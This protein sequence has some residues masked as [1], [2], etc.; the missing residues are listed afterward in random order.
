MRI[1]PN[2]RLIEAMA[3]QPLSWR[4]ALTEWID[5]SLD[6]GATAVTVTVSRAKGKSLVRIDDNGCG[7]ESLE[8]FFKFGD[9]AKHKTS[10]S[11]RYGIG[12]KDAA[13]YLGGVQSVFHVESVRAGV[14]RVQF[15]DWNR[16]IQRGEW[17]IDDHTETPVRE[18]HPSG[19]TIVVAPVCRQVPSGQGWTRLLDELAYIYSPALLRGVQISVRP[20]YDRDSKREPVALLKGWQPTKEIEPD[21]IQTEIEVG[22]K[23]AKVYAAIVRDGIVNER[24]GVTYT[25]GFRVIVPSTH[26]GCG[27]A[28]ISRI[29][30]WVHIDDSWARN[31][32]KDGIRDFEALA[33]AVEHA[34]APILRRAEQ[35][36]SELRSAAFTSAVQ[37]AVNA[38]LVNDAK[39]VRNKRRNP[40]GAVRPTGTGSRHRNAAQKQPG[41]TMPSRPVGAL[42]IV[43]AHLGADGGA[44]RL[45]GGVVTLNLDNAGI[46]AARDSE[47]VLA[48]KFAID[49]ILAAEYAIRGAS[50]LRLNVRNVGDDEDH[51][52]SFSAV[53]GD[54]LAA[55][56]AIDGRPVLAEVSDQAAE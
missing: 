10:K 19:T 24:P 36:G 4:V 25:H 55:A 6:A 30:A 8:P 32:N 16:I 39:A 28:P 18:G 21:H 14:R 37:N 52:R 51:A 44:G 29:V 41:E 50:Q 53:Y 13:L 35:A 9:H 27:N 7:R 2:A 15:A 48:A 46:R 22:G 33:R 23:R 17:E 43:Y 12:A 11:G 31:K 42:R 45:D 40:T 38:S 47:N 20:G 1:D 56:A 26:H 34:I 49:G 5:N 3:E 54:L